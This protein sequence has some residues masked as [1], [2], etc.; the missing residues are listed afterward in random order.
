[1][2]NPNDGYEEWK[3]REDGLFKRFS[4][5]VNIGQ[6]IAFILFLCFGYYLVSTNKLPNGTF[7]MFTFAII[8]IG[9]F[10]LIKEGKDKKLI[11]EKIIKEIAQRALERKRREGIEIPF[12]YQVKVLP[13][14]H[15]VYST[16]YALDD[17]ISKPVS[18]DV[19][20][21]ISKG[22]FRK[23]GVIKI[24]PTDGSCLGLRWES[25]GYSGKESK[26]FILVPVDNIKDTSEKR[27]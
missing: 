8:L 5:K 6:F 19:G 16:N 15:L 2:D 7:W 12:D 18:W 11:P 27:N 14:C 21:Q 22:G 25:L 9:I 26:D 1:M 10:I 4:K 23:I 20:F 3:R 13:Q 17:S 24:H